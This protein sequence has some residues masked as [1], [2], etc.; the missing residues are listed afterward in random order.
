[1]AVIVEKRYGRKRLIECML[2]PRELLVSYNQAAKE[3][4]NNRQEKLALW[5]P[6]L[7]Q[8]INLRMAKTGP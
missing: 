1:M 3:K 7:I 5:S 6:E 4:N 2:D 8:K